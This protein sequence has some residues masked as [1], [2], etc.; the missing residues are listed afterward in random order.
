MKCVI[1]IINY[2]KSSIPEK[3]MVHNHFQKVNR[4]L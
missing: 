1:N 4:A 3:D 2:N